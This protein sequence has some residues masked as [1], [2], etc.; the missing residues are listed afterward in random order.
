MGTAQT[1]VVVGVSAVLALSAL[2]V[3]AAQLDTAGASRCSTHAYL[4]DPDPKG[5]NVRAAPSAKAPVVGRLPPRAPMEDAPSEIVGVE[6]EIVGS[7]DG[8]LLVRDPDRGAFKGPGWIFGGLVSGTLGGAKL[9]AAPAGNAKVVASLQHL[10]ETAIGADSFEVLQVHACQG[11]YVD[12]TVRLAPS[13]EPYPGLPKQP[14][15]GW[16]AKMCS[17]QLTTCD[18]SQRAE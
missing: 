6:F 5:T 3:R 1:S 16:V 18:S 12:V 9:L 10:G 14:M 11:H 4:N 7:K 13:I 2:P 8:W 17:T 15:R